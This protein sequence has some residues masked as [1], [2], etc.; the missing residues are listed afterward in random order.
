LSNHARLRFAKCRA[1]AFVQRS[2]DSFFLL[3][4]WALPLTRPAYLVAFSGSYLIESKLK[5]VLWH[6]GSG[7]GFEFDAGVSGLE[8]FLACHVPRHERSDHSHSVTYRD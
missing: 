2:P 6:P 5:S 7:S 4:V 1:A 3:L 8:R